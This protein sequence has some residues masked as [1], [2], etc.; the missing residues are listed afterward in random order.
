[1]ICVRHGLMI[2]GEPFA[3]KSVSLLILANALTRLAGRGLLNENKVL[4]KKMN[5]KALTMN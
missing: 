5:P 2:V 1:M 3:G 4:V